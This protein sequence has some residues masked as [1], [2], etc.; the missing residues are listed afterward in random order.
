M[1]MWARNVSFTE[2]FTYVLY[3]WYQHTKIANV[4][5]KNE[6][7]KDTQLGRH[8][9]LIPKKKTCPSFICFLSKGAPFLYPTSQTSKISNFGSSCI[10]KNLRCILFTIHAWHEGLHL[11]DFYDHCI[12][13]RIWVKQVVYIFT[14]CA[15]LSRTKSKWLSKSVIFKDLTARFWEIFFRKGSFFV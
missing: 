6:N 9:F 4:K 12:F 3:G 7:V 14:F 10:R 13:W 15:W 8:K 2:Y 1:H 11:R 5:W